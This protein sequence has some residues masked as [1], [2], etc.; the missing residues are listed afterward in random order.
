MVDNSDQVYS[1]NL[2]IFRRTMSYS[3]QPE[4]LFGNHLFDKNPRNKQAQQILKSLKIIFFAKK[5]S[6]EN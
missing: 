4:F 5:V 2:S 1:P 3:S 6:R